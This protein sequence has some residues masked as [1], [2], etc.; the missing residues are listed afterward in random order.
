MSNKSESK[1]ET[2]VE[3]EAKETK[4]KKKSRR[5]KLADYDPDVL[6]SLSKI[7]VRALKL[8]DLVTISLK[9]GQ[10]QLLATKLAGVKADE[11]DPFGTTQDVSRAIKLSV[12]IDGSKAKSAKADVLKEWDTW[13]TIAN[14]IK[15]GDVLNAVFVVEAGATPIASCHL[16]CKR[17]EKISRYSLV[18]KFA[19]E[20]VR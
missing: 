5:K 8:C 10:G 12:T 1:E 13:R 9:D 19:P 16:L 14:L 7:D 15:P 11:D 3:Q 4:R 18:S 20:L 17:R 6:G 2:V